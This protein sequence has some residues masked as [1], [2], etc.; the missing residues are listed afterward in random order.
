MSHYIAE[1]GYGVSVITKAVQAVTGSLT[2]K[3][4]HKQGTHGDVG[5]Q[6]LGSS[7]RPTEACHN[8]S[9]SCS[10]EAFAQN[11]DNKI[12]AYYGMP[13]R[14]LDTESRQKYPSQDSSNNKTITWV[15]DS[16]PMILL[17]P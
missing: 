1:T 16:R 12:K 11:Q 14:I 5:F 17:S 7:R 9:I 3:T 2:E 15:T 4:Q 8:N 6:D 10:K 13:T